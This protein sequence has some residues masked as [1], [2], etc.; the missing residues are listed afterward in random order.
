MKSFNYGRFKI[1]YEIR[2]NGCWEVVNRSI[3]IYGYP[4]VAFDGKHYNAHRLVYIMEVNPEIDSDIYVCHS[5]DN[6]LCVN[7]A[8]LFEGSHLDNMRDKEI[9]GRGNQPLGE[10]VGISKLTEN[11]IILIRELY[12]AGAKTQFELASLFNVD[13]SNISYIINNKTW[14]HV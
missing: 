9:K 4:K 14:K 7:P 13:Q 12:Y 1:Q 10:K 3:S 6:K 11:D 5:C 2:E 8:H